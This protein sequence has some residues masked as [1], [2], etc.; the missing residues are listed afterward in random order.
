MADLDGDG[1]LDLRGEAGGQLQAF[2]SEAPEAW[3]ALGLL[4]TAEPPDRFVAEV[5]PPAADID[6]QGRSSVCLSFGSP[7]ADFQGVRRIVVLDPQGR[8]RSD[9]DLGGRPDN[10]GKAAGSSLARAV[11]LTGDGRDEVI[12]DSRGRHRVWGP[13]LKE[14]W[15][16]QDDMRRADQIITGPA[17]QPAMLLLNHAEVAFDGA[18]GH[19]RW[20]SGAAHPGWGQFRLRFLGPGGPAREPLILAHDLGTTTCRQAILTTS[21]GTIVPPR[22][23]PV[24]PGLVREDPR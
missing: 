15:S 11:D 14:L 21:G 4:G 13:D 23:N 9:R 12:F 24:P 6:G 10:S 8:V 19:P 17:R 3:R 5:A 16:W 7:V 2:R 20:T 22:V 1:L 18:D